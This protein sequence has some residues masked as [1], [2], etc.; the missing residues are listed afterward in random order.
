MFIGHGPF[1][2]SVI[3]EPRQHLPVQG[4]YGYDNSTAAVA[5]P[6]KHGR[7]LDQP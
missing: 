4:I 5:E 1:Q 2:V 3:A 7:S 6:F